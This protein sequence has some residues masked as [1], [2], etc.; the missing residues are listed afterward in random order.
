MKE[1]ATAS[2]LTY[3]LG[4]QN[5]PSKRGQYY[6]FLIKL[7]SFFTISEE[8]LRSYKN[9]LGDNILIEHTNMS[10]DEKICLKLIHTS[11]ESYGSFGDN[12]RCCLNLADDIIMS[13]LILYKHQESTINKLQDLKLQLNTLED[14]MQ[15]LQ[16]KIGSMPSPDTANS[17]VI[18]QLNESFEKMIQPHSCLLSY[19]IKEAQSLQESLSNCRDEFWKLAIPVGHTPDEVW[20]SISLAMQSNDSSE[21][22]TKILE[23]RNSIG[24][25]RRPIKKITLKADQPSKYKFNIWDNFAR[26]INDLCR[27]T[28][29]VHK[30]IEKES[31]LQAE[32]IPLL[33]NLMNYIINV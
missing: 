16:S 22:R 25:Q 30:D 5:N 32:F 9:E 10:I 26:A 18:I 7:V 29:I 31:Q 1:I 27:H 6:D 4:G 17:D 20:N 13:E 3:T 8:K 24:S 15:N 19:R 2:T 28:E 11:R 21:F 12:L 14:K 23:L 33:T